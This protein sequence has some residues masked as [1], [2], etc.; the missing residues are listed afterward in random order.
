MRKS[1]KKP[2]DPI[3]AEALEQAFIATRLLDEKYFSDFS[4]A[5]G[6]QDKELFEKVCKKAK[7]SDEM[8]QKIW[9]YVSSSTKG[10]MRSGVSGP[11]W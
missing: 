7:I 10:T 8:E 3:R 6:T 2:I 1:V 4:K 11:V 5:V 9:E